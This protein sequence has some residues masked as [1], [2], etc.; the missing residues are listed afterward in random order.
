MGQYYK[1]ISIENMYWVYSHDYGNGLKLMEH[2]YIGNN[3]VGV[4]MKLLSKGGDWYKTPLVWCGDYFS[5]DG[6][7]NYYEKATDDTKIK[8]KEFMKEKEQVKSILVNHTKKQYVF[9]SEEDYKGLSDV[10]KAN[11]MLKVIEEGEDDYKIHPLPLLTALGNGRGGGDFRG[12]N[13]MIGYWARDIISVE[14][15]I[16]E[17][18]SQLNVYFVEER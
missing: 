7:E 18:Y 11:K 8:P 10:K 9:V 13:D 16:P 5:E 2:S 12:E 14:T 15:E 3:F 17:G 4:V 6:E 1:P